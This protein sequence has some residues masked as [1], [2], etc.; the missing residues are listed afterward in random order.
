M[1]RLRSYFNDILTKNPRQQTTK[2][3]VPKD[4]ASWTHVFLRKDSVRAPLTPPYTGPYRVLVRTD[5]LFTLDVCGKKET[6][7]IDR[8]K[9]TFAYTDTQE[10]HIPSTY[11]LHQPTQDAHSTMYTPPSLTYVTTTRSG[12]RVHC[13]TVYI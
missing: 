4:I 5:K 12:R 13:K 9:W 1:N 10:P 6:V 7:S 11:T 2:S 8:V 3:S